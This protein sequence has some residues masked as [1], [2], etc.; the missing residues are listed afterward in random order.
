MGNPMTTVF[1]TIDEM[2]DLDIIRYSQTSEGQDS[3]HLSEQSPLQVLRE[4]PVNTFIEITEIYSQR[5]RIAQK[6]N[7]IKCATTIKELLAIVT[8]LVEN[9]NFPCDN[10]ALIINGN[11]LLQSH[12]DYDVH[13]A[14]ENFEFIRDLVQKVLVRQHYDQSLLFKIISNP[15]LYHK[16]ERPDKILFRYR[17]LDEVLDAL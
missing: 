17:T 11:L 10:L 3:F 9:G 7:Q 1:T 15:D 8:P 14:S 6:V 2:C 16:L 4:L 5:H 12:N 13:L